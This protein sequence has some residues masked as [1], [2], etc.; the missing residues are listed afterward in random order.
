MP[1]KPLCIDLFCGLG[2]WTEGFLAEGWD[3]VGF[4]NHQHV[5]GDQKYP[6]QLVLQDVITLT[7]KQFSKASII[8]ASP[9]CQEYSMMAMPFSYGKRV[10]SALLGQGEFPDMWKGSRTIAELTALYDACF[11]IAKEAGVP[12]VVENVKGAQPWVGKARAHFGS[13][14]LWGDIEQVGR[15]VTRF[16]PVFG[17]TVRPAKGS[18]NGQKNGTE[19]AMTRGAVESIKGN[20]GGWFGTYADQKAE[21]RVASS[22]QTSSNSPAR[23]AASAQIATNS[24]S[25]KPQDIFPIVT[26]SSRDSIP[27][28]KQPLHGR[29]PILRFQLSILQT[30]KRNPAVSSARKLGQATRQ[31]SPPSPNPPAPRCRRPSQPLGPGTANITIAIQNLEGTVVNVSESVI[32]TGGDVTG[33]TVFQHHASVS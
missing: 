10:A 30:L 16:P 18:K 28:C 26:F 9:P 15:N 11:R 12:L 31:Q 32:V 8:V 20:G 14:Y 25:R 23:K 5:Y 29:W 1:A 33:G 21:G 2:G 4:D 13:F 27:R 24:I 6:A 19:Y 22:R 17:A 3:V 7:G